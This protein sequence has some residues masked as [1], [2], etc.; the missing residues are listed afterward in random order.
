MI[1]AFRLEEGRVTYGN[2]WMRA[3][4]FELERA[5]GRTLFGAF[6]NPAETDPAARGNDFGV[7]NTHVV[8]HAGRLLALEESHL[9][10]AFDPVMLESHGYHDFGGAA[11]RTS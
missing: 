11:T 6:G 1:R 8:H 4:K 2:R 7:A 3:P 5:A 10:F 9:P